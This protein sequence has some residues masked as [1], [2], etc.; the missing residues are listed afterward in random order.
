MKTR[1]NLL[2]LSKPEELLK[3]TEIP[4]EEQKVIRP[5]QLY[6]LATSMNR[7]SCHVI[8]NDGV[9]S[10]CCVWSPDPL[11]NG[12]ARCG[13]F[14][15]TILA[16]FSIILLLIGIIL[17][18]LHYVIGMEFYT[19][20]RGQTIGPL[21]LGLTIIPLIFMIYFICIARHKITDYV[22]QLSLNYLAKE[23]IAYRQHQAE[24]A[25]SSIGLQ[26]SSR[27]S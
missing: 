25:R 23:R 2:P 3:T 12:P 17:T 7:N 14:M 26:N 13:C 6:H 22:E 15:A 5:H 20:N 9:H 8:Y 16:I 18:I 11:I 1:N 19:I 27:Y 21:L 4:L 10:D 24:L